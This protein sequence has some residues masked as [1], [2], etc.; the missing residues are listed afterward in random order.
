[1]SVTVDTLSRQTFTLPFFYFLFSQACLAPHWQ[2]FPSFKLFKSCWSLILFAYLLSFFLFSFLNNAYMLSLVQVFLSFCIS[3]IRFFQVHGL[4]LSGSEVSKLQ[5]TFRMEQCQNSNCNFLSCTFSTSIV[6]RR[7]LCEK[8]SGIVEVQWV[9]QT[10][11]G[12][13]IC[14]LV[15]FADIRVIIQFKS[16]RENSMKTPPLLSS[17]NSINQ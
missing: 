1:M 14:L 5:V 8:I 12:F 4:V 3:Y 7:N 13:Q 6:K 2:A 9:Q 11:S 17:V 10:C 16:C 15:V